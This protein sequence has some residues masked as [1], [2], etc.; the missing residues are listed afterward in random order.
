MREASAPA[1]GLVLPAAHLTA[2][3]GCNSAPWRLLGRS[4][5]VRAR[6]ERRGWPCGE[7]E[8]TELPGSRWEQD[9][10]APLASRPGWY[11]ST[12]Q[13]P[14]ALASCVPAPHPRATLG[15]MGEG[16][17]RAGFPERPAAPPCF[18]A[19]RGA[20]GSVLGSDRGMRRTDPCLKQRLPAPGRGPRNPGGLQ[21]RHL[22]A[23]LMRT[24]SCCEKLVRP[25]VD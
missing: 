5:A 8:R 20:C 9:P 18:C 12:G 17:Q 10:A 3:M 22:L 1:S 21:H 2:G 4:G 13:H 25:R 6:P 16:A 7:S 23:L 24:P 14:P 19:P 11:P 15:I